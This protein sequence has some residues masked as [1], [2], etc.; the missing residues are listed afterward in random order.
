MAPD[1]G[2]TIRLARYDIGQGANPVRVPDRGDE[3]Q[4]HV[5]RGPLGPQ[6][7]SRASNRYLCA[8]A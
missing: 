3:E 4:E 6:R 1:W 8:D 7:P 5:G 2:G